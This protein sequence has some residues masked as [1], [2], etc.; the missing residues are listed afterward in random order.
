M[1]TDNVNLLLLR[2]SC[3]LSILGSLIVMLVCKTRK[4]LE[5]QNGRHLIFWLSFSDFSSSFIY[6]LSS[7]LIK[8]NNENTIQ[9]K[10][11][12]LLGIFFPVA[13]FLWTDFIAYYLYSMIVSRKFKTEKEWS[14]LMTYFHIISWGLSAFC[15][16]IV[17]SFDHAGRSEENGNVDNTG[18]WCWVMAS[19]KTLILWE[20][21]GGKLIEWMSAF[22]ILPYLYFIT[23]RTLVNL[24]NSWTNFVENNKT[25][26]KKETFYQYSKRNLTSFI[27]K[28]LHEVDSSSSEPLLQTND[29]YYDDEYSDITSINH[30]NHKQNSFDE[31]EHIE[32]QTKSNTTNNTII[33]GNHNN[34]KTENG[35]KN[36]PKFRKFYTKMVRNH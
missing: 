35:T 24:D 26:I 33:N 36:T 31:R 23:A 1:K 32:A 9:C 6:L 12:A 13:S 17:A 7:F 2:L 22:I 11:F 16:L 4:I 10:V 8:D 21:I 15:I 14:N 5:K 30:N 34:Q 20:I 27:D 3:F 25:G 18:G 19:S 29:L 28:Y